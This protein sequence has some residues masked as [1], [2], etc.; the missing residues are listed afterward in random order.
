MIK[1]LK[2]KYINPAIEVS[3]WTNQPLELLKADKQNTK[4]TSPPLTSIT[5]S[6]A[7]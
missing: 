4:Y 6:T 5:V 7:H 3:A 2:S 1:S